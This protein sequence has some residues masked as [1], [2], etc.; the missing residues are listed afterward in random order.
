MTVK[1]ERPESLV[2]EQMCSTRGLEGATS[3]IVRRNEAT[4]RVG[5]VPGTYGEGDEE[6]SRGQT[7]V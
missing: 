4:P 3:G 6:S 7:P 2:R 5:T 1:T